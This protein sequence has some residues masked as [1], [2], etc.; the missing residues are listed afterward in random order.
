[1]ILVRVEAPT[2]R[3][4][5]AL[6]AVLREDRGLSVVGTRSSLVT[7]DVV[8]LKR[9]SIPQL[10]AATT[11][12]A[13]AAPTAPT[14]AVVMLLDDLDREAAA[15]AVRAGALAVLPADA[16]PLAIRAAVHAAAAGLA[17]LPAGFRTG[18]LHSSDDAPPADAVGHALTAREGEILALLGV[19]LA[20]KQIGARLGISQH[21]VKTH[22]AAIYEKLGASNRAEAV[23]TGLRRGLILL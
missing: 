15:A 3:A 21:T 5:R 14:A 8:V 18:L 16:E 9:D 12:T 22:V 7:P 20:N 13:P 2:A 19:G 23:A 11:P 1:V 4:R 17:S 10:L 6:E